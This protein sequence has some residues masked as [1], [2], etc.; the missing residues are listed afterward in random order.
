MS[1]TKAG[2]GRPK[3]SGLDD[4]TRLVAIEKLMAEDPGLRPTTAIK[5]IG[6]TDPSVVRRLRDKLNHQ[7]TLQSADATLPPDVIAQATKPPVE[8]QR[9][10]SVSCPA[11]PEAKVKERA[12]VRRTEPQP[13]APAVAKLKV[14]SISSSSSSEASQSATASVSPGLEASSE[15]LARIGGLGLKAFVASFEFQLAC[16][17]QVMRLLPVTAALKQQ[18]L[19]N[20]MS[21]AFLPGSPPTRTLH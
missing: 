9:P 14:Q 6:V 16:L 8:A 2:R 20:E 18:L 15:W 1:E 3:G 11:V 17:G 12:R 4:S 21:L 13:P 19:L 10:T 5:Q 7:R